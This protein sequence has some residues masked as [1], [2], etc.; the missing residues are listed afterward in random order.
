MANT[1]T[2]RNWFPGLQNG[3]RERYHSS[4]STNLH[5]ENILWRAILSSRS[6][7]LQLPFF[8]YLNPELGDHRLST[9]FVRIAFLCCFIAG[10]LCCARYSEDDLWYR[11]QVK[12]VARQNPL[13]VRVVYVDYGTTEVVNADRWSASRMPF[14]SL[15]FNHLTQIYYSATGKPLNTWNIS[16]MFIVLWPITAKISTRELATK[17]QTAD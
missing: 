8:S 13:E 17:P 5:A 12:S 16:G 1:I 11:A 7:H 3:E 15:N 6:F 10:M 2:V 9:F 4:T 14:Y